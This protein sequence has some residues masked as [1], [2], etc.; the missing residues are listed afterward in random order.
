[1]KFLVKI[2]LFL[3]FAQHSIKANAQAFNIGNI[4]QAEGESTFFHYLPPQ[5]LIQVKKDQNVRMGGSY[6]TQDSSFITIKFFDGSW[7]RISPK[8]KISIEYLPESKQILI[9][10]FTGSVKTLFS[11]KLSQGGIL[12]FVVKSADTFFE[13][14]GAKF[15]V[16]RNAVSNTNSI[17]VEKGSVIIIQNVA[18]ER[19]D[20]EI[21]HRNEMTSV[22]D[23]EHDIMS[24]RKMS[25]GEVKFLHPSKYLKQTNSKL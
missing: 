2:I 18:N 1:M 14:V 19:K 10:L 4:T 5:R 13:T 22:K 9:H 25:E 21:V 11:R 7:L 16:V 3:L 12:K 6:L 20:M 15:S 17:Y 24:P 8:S 23:N